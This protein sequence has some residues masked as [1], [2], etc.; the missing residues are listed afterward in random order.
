MSP[1]G[2]LFVCA[3]DQL[4]LI[5]S[6]TDPG[7]SL[8][9]WIFAPATIFMDL[10]RAA[11]A[12]TSDDTFVMINSTLFTFS[13]ISPRGHLPLVSRLLITTGLNGIVINCTDISTMETASA[14]IYAV[15]VQGMLVSYDI[16]ISSILFI[17]TDHACWE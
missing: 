2:N 13:R 8:L 15:N 16:I 7:S 3:G 17:C 6:L 10:Q 14:T 9:E 5:C 12:S 11:D 4:E 1:S